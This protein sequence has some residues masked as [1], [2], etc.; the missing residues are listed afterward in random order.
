MPHALNAAF[1]AKKVF[2]ERSMLPAGDTAA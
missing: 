2:A 1:V